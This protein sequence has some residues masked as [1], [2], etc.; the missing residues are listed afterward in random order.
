MGTPNRLQRKVKTIAV[1]DQDYPLNL[2][3]IFDPPPMLYIKG[4]L[5]AE[6][7]LAVAIVGSRRATYYGLKNA[8]QLGYQLAARGITIVSGLARGVDSAAHRGA[9]A[10]KGRTIAV[11]GSGLNMIYPPEHA[12]LADQIAESGAVVSEFTLDTPPHKQN[13][14]RRNRI[15][16]G[17]SLAVVVI[18]AARKSGALIT[19]HCALE[20]GREVC[21]LP[22]KVDSLT[23][24]GTHEL[25][26]EGAKLVQSV[27]DIIEEL[28]PLQVYTAAVALEKEAG[29]QLAVLSQEEQAVCALLNSEGRS[30]DSIIEKAG[31]GYGVL[32]TTLLRL[33]QKKL[34]QELPGKRYVRI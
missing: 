8:E 24:F 5:V 29:Q 33:Q 27:E 32:M 19:A 18:E 6:D 23:S 20:Q 2:R 30:L 21:A 4:D 17:L 13:F 26:K 22:G 10:A 3:Y 9:L 15:I 16:S 12:A 34:V 31:L 11:L 25:I 14:P 7:A 1:K 28:Q